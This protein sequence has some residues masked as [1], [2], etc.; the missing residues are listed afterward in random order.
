MESLELF[1]KEFLETKE[2]FNS[3]GYELI[4]TNEGSNKVTYFTVKKKEKS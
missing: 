3:M 4:G 1:A 2:K